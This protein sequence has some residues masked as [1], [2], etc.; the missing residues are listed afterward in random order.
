MMFGFACDETPELM[1]MPISLARK[2][3]KRLTY[4]RNEKILNYLQPDGKT[5]VTVEYENHI[6]KRIDAIVISTQ[7]A[8]NITLETI[9]KYIVE[10]VIEPINEI[11]LKISY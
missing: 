3:A 9:R 1:P 4:V 11:K 8:K 6:P 2:L 7:H 5:Q 10:N